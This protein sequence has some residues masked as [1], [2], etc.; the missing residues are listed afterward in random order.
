MCSGKQIRNVAAVGGNI[1][2]GSPI[3]DLNPIFMAAQAILSIRSADKKCELPFDE[4]FYTGYRR[5]ALKPH[6]ILV[7]IRIPFTKSTQHF[8]AYKQARRRDDDIAIVNAAF[9]IKVNSDTKQID[10]IVMAFGGMGPTTLLACKTMKVLEGLEINEKLME[11]ACSSLK[12]ELS[13]EPNAPGAMVRYRQSLVLSFFFKAYLSISQVTGSLPGNTA[14]LPFEKA[15]LQSHQL[16]EIKTD[17]SN[18]GAVGKPIK[19]KSANHQVDGTAQ[20]T[21]DIP[22]IDGEL[23]AGLVLSTKAHADIVCIDASAALALEGVCDW[24]SSKDLK[25]GTNIFGTA[26]F[27]DEVVFAEDRVYCVGMIIG[28]IIAD[29]QENAQKASRMVKIEY[30]ELP[31][32]ITIEDAIKNNSYHTPLNAGITSGDVDLIFSDAKNIIEG[33]MRTGAQEQFYLET[34][35]CIAI[36]KNENDEMEI[37]SSTQNPTLTQNIVAGILGVSA[38]RFVMF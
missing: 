28:L 32:I 34:N 6:E 20:Y 38:N 25:D 10:K 23:Y 18:L 1:M 24:V 12:E 5:N 21:D 33:E 29:S 13:L 37:W 36:P 31:P 2:T 15:P 26:V 9:N 17:Q 35:A 27:K 3:S 7:S 22:H 16:C 4:H 8:F 30:K 14:T 19:H 11:T